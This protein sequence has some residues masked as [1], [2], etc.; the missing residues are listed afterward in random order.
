MKRSSSHC[1]KSSIIPNGWLEFSN[2]NICSSTRIWLLWNPRVVTLQV[3][4]VEA[5]LIH[6][7]IRFATVQLYFSPCYGHN[8]YIQRR[9]LWQSLVSKNNCTRPWV[10]A[11]GFNTIRWSHEENRRGEPKS[12]GAS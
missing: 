4:D 2:A 1:L 11:V 5:Q 3:L 8:S 10:V 7:D 9:E 6:C 12:F